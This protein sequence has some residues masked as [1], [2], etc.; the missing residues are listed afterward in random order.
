MKEKIHPEYRPVAFKDNSVQHIFIVRSTVKT[1]DTV[2]VDGV[3]Y[4]AVNLDVSDKSHPFY[5][6]K[7]KV[8]DIAGRIDK[9]KKRYGK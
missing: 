5:T 3:T 6:G 9:F 8:L 4:P 7:S 1:K 2:V